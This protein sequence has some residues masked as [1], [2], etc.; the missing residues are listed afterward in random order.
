MEVTFQIALICRYFIEVQLSTLVGI[1]VIVYKMCR[2][3]SQF[4]TTDVGSESALTSFAVTSLRYAF[5][6]SLATIF[7]PTAA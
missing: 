5:N 3:F 4:M 7:P 1:L 2:H 6:V